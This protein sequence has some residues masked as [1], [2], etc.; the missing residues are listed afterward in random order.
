MVATNG[1]PA[2]GLTADGPPAKKKK[3]SKG[4]PRGVT[5]TTSG[6]FQGRANYKAPGAKRGIQRHV[7]TF[8]TAEEA[9]QAV[10]DAEVK[11]KAEGEGSVWTGP[12]RKNE[13]RRGEVRCHD[14]AHHSAH[15]HHCSPRTIHS[16]C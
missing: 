3:V 6:K 7:G 1:E 9:G 2:A 16:H 12:A 14:S 8:D 11:L 13:H 5:E 4:L 10:A 15:H